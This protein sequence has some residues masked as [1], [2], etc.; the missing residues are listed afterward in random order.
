MTPDVGP[1]FLK[2]GL[3]RFIGS[4][5][6][7]EAGPIIIASV[8]VAPGVVKAPFGLGDPVA[9]SFQGRRSG[10]HGGSNLPDEPLDGPEGVG[11]GFPVQ[12]GH[13]VKG[14]QHEMLN[15]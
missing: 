13:A 5:L 3:S 6:G 7:R 8:Q 4:L 9:A 10:C 2:D 1:K 12:L 14:I 11:Q 15:A